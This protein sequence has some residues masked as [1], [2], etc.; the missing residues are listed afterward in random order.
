MVFV[1][2]ELLNAVEERLAV[3][4]VERVVIG[5]AYTAVRLS[6]GSVGLAA[7]PSPG[8][9][10]R[11]HPRAGELARKSALNLAQ[12]LL[13]VNPLDSALGLATVNAVLG[14][15]AHPSPDPVEAMGIKNTDV[16]GVVGYIGPLVQ[17]LEGRAREVLVFER[18]PRGRACSPIERWKRSLAGAM[19]FSLPEQPSPTKRWG[20]FWNWPAAGWQ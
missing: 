10:C 17:A 12:G 8:W 14:K 13:S 19:W 1:I 20:G 6:D 11:T 7:T 2:R 15:T 18:I 4:E 9:G 16:V 5:V 3:L